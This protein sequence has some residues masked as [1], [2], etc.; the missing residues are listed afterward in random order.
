MG[1]ELW[2]WRPTVAAGSL[3]DRRAAPASSRSAKKRASGSTSF[4]VLRCRN[5][6]Q[7]LGSVRQEYARFKLLSLRQLLA[8]ALSRITEGPPSPEA[9]FRRD[10]HNVYPVPRHHGAAGS[11]RGMS[12][13]CR[14]MKCRTR[15][16][17]ALRR[18]VEFLA[19]PSPGTATALSVTQAP[20]RPLHPP[21][22]TGLGLR[23]SGRSD[24][25]KAA[26]QVV[27]ARGSALHRRRR[28][29]TMRVAVHK[30]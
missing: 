5:T 27:R 3:R 15:A 25:L 8:A 6:R 26:S 11:S 16:I 7:P 4:R 30:C 13:P 19:R 9:R 14:L 2:R 18:A 24:G 1:R 28:K 23:S 10:V 12:A 22:N 29:G 17:Y 20:P 21:R